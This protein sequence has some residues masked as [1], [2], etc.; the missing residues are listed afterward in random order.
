MATV[1]RRVEDAVAGLGVTCRQCGRCCDF[2][3][4]RVIAFASSPEIAF[5]THHFPHAATR[6]LSDGRCSLLREAKCSVHAARPLGCR[7][8]FCTHRKR[9]RLEAIYEIYYHEIK[10]IA[11]EHDIPWSYER[12]LPE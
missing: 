3:L 7:T 9:V 10:R 5:L 4:S 11:A 1:Y 2:E 12:F 6:H 8:Y